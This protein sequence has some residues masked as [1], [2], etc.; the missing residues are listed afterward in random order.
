MKWWSVVPNAVCIFAIDSESNVN[1]S[2]VSMVN[3]PSNLLKQSV[4]GKASKRIVS[5]YTLKNFIID[6]NTNYLSYKSLYLNNT[7]LT[8]GPDITIPTDFTFILKCK[9]Y[10]N[11]VFLSNNNSYRGLQFLPTERSTWKLEVFTT[12][13]TASKADFER[14]LSAIHTIILRGSIAQINIEMITDFG[15]FILPNNSPIFTSFLGPTRVFNSIGTGTSSVDRPDTDI[16]A[17]G[18]F[19]K[20]FTDDELDSIQR[21]IDE[22]FLLDSR[23][24]KKTMKFNSKISSNIIFKLNF[25]IKDTIKVSSIIED[26]SPVPTYMRF[27]RTLLPNLYASSKLYKNMKDISDTILEEGQPIIAKLFLYE[28]GTG[29]LLKIT[30]SDIHGRFH[31]YNLSRDYEYRVTSNDPKYQ[32]RT[33]TKTYED[34]EI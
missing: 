11:S 17:Y 12:G 3:Q 13:D 32:F 18:L 30:T 14:S 23:T 25:K 31:F 27:N 7:N 29:T 2:T 34:F 28:R 5:G 22:Q 15:T 10:N 33:I 19:N 8:L 6:P 9:V 4:V 24:V 26:S 1:S 16:I 21:K 20:I